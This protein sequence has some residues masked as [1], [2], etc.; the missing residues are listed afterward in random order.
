MIRLFDTAHGGGP[1]LEAVGTVLA[2]DDVIVARL[3][4]ESGRELFAV[5]GSPT[6]MSPRLVA[7]VTRNS[8]R[9]TSTTCWRMWQ[10]SQIEPEVESA[11]RSV[12]VA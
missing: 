7:S 3:A 11:A 1:Q 2:H 10:T 4:L 5:P 12:P 8:L 9:G 6:S